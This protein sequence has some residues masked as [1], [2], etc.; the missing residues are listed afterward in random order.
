MIRKSEVDN[1]TKDEEATLLS[2][3]V[4]ISS[5]VQSS[6]PKPYLPSL[7]AVTHREGKLLPR[8]LLAP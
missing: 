2:T 7:K 6:P 4:V 3:G 5:P 8:G 1:C